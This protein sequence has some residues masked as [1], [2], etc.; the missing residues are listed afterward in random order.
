MALSDAPPATPSDAAAA[1]AGIPA[2]VT[3]PATATMPVSASRMVRE[4]F[5]G[6]GNFFMKF[7]MPLRL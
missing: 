5:F 4:R 6:D 2:L 7:R 3:A 1:A